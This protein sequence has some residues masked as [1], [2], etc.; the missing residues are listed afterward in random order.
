MKIDEYPSNKIKKFSIEQFLISQDFSRTIL[1]KKNKMKRKMYPENCI[2]NFELF[3]FVIVQ[4]KMFLIIK[5]SIF[6][7]ICILIFENVK[8]YFSLQLF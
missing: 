6:I 1:A 7:S 2:S 5:F 4:F 3:Y 8:F